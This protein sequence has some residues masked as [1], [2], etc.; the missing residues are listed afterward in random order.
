MWHQIFAF[1]L[2]QSLTPVGIEVRSE[3]QARQDPSEGRGP[4]ERHGQR[5]AADQA[6]LEHWGI[7]IFEA[8]SLEELLSEEA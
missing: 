5:Q 4:A 2:E 1:L 6:T 7:R 3:V 8:A